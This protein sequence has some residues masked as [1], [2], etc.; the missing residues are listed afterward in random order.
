MMITSIS[1]TSNGVIRQMVWGTE[2]GPSY[3]HYFW[4][5]FYKV[6]MTF[7]SLLYRMLDAIDPML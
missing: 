1:K 3:H 7:N 6:V 2:N 4:S 5:Q